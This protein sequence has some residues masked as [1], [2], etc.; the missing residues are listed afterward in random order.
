MEK[1]KMLAGE[2]YI[3]MDPE[4]TSDHLHAQD[5][6]FRFNAMRPDVDAERRALLIELL[7]TFGEGTVI[8]PSFRC[9]YGYNIQIG[10]NSF[11]NY[12]CVF[13][14]CNRITI[15]DFVQIGPSVQIYTAQH[16]TDPET[17]RSGLEYA[18]PVTIGDNV[19]IGGGAIVC[20]G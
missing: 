9:D 15:G 2:L 7:G 3:A 12:D 20:P 4:L 6:L 14:D 17:R 10:R 1:Q 8:K 16:P 13:L 5:L 19:W 18:L 11:V